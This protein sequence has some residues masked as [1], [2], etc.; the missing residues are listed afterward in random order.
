MPKTTFTDSQALVY[1]LVPPGDYVVEV[2]KAEAGLSKDG[3]TRGCDIFD[4]QVAVENHP[5]CRIWDDLTFG[6]EKLQWKLDVFVKAMN[7]TINEQGQYDP[8]GRLPRKGESFDM[9][10]ED[11][12][13]LRGWVS[14]GVREYMPTPK[15][16][17]DKPEKKKINEIK[18]WLT[19]KPKLP[20]NMPT[21]KPEEK[22]EIPF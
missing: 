9:N 16:P 18:V 17:D 21:A 6:Y 8:A 20:R 3:K 1:E 14:I 22:E 5:N 7:F 15:G 10:V 2:I 4:V 12:L 13:G 11:L 19:D